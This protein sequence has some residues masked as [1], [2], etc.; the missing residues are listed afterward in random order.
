M[1]EDSN[2][3]ISIDKKIKKYFIYHLSGRDCSWKKPTACII[4][5]S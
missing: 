4:S 5:L 3:I 1:P 2:E